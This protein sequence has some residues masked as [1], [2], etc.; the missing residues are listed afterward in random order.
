M[1]DQIIV[2]EH[3]RPEPPM[4]A[5]EAATMLGFLEFQRATFAWKTD[6]LDADGLRAK[7]AAS[8]MTLGGMLKHLAYVEDV[9]FSRCL[10]GRDPALWLPQDEAVWEADRDWDWNTAASD[11]PEQL[12]ALWRGAVT[13]SRADTAE[14]I[15]SGGLGQLARSGHDGGGP[16]SLRWIL[17]HM[18]EEYARHNGHADL[19][20][21]AVDG[22]TGE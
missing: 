14:A 10:N 5:S 1:T 11:S 7:T 21:E 9:W 20:R 2:D 4:A 22:Q 8:S 13:R 15:A 3:G 19:I 6:G 18:V 17:C 16:P 12:R